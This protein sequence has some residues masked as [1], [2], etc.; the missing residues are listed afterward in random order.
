MNILD[1]MPLLSLITGA[2]LVVFI[3]FRKY[4]LASRKRLK[5][6]LTLL[7]FCY[8]FV[9]LDYYLFSINVDDKYIGGSY[10]FFHLIGFLFYYFVSLFINRP[11]KLMKWI[12]I[13]VLYTI[14]RLVY[15]I[16]FFPTDT[17][18]EYFAGYNN[19]NRTLEIEYIITST[20]NIILMILAYRK[21][22]K[23]PT[24]IKADKKTFI[25]EKWIRLT[26]VSN[27]VVMALLLISSFIYTIFSVDAFLYVKIEMLI[28]AIFMYTLIF[29]MLQFPVFVYT[30]K[31]DD[32]SDNVKQKY[33]NST[34]T[35]SD[36]LYTEILNVVNDEKLYLEF[37]LKM[38]T[39]A[40]KLDRTVHHI[41]Q[42]INENAQM[43][44]PDFINKL[45]VDRAK[46]LLLKPEPDTV[47]AIALDVGFNSKATFY[48]AFRKFTGQTP[49]EFRKSNTK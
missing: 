16:L 26:I 30:G 42:A 11:I 43:S 36:E 33:N 39:I 6:V 19:F 3:A 15:L 8:T 12:V 45:R 14:V 37:G 47:F 23:T 9:S 41:S 18:S 20:V 44:F 38:N 29:S 35:N 24:C 7:V 49:T 27:I 31:Y 32:L 21:L 1:F 34:L 13:W 4:G 10:L 40:V 5:T 17:I 25:Y 22:V 28:Y 48:T 2:L 46:K